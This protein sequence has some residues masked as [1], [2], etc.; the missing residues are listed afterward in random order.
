MTSQV[1]RPWVVG[2][3]VRRDFLGTRSYRL[4]FLLD[5]SYGVLDLVLYYFISQT[6]AGFTSEE[7]SGAPSYFAFAAAGIVLGVVITASSSGVAF[8]LREEQVTGTLEAMSTEPVTPFEICV[9]LVGFPFAFAAARSAFYLAIA[10][11]FLDL[12]LGDT[13]WPGLVLVLVASGAAL[14]PLGVLAG[15]AVLVFKRGTLV[16]GTLMYLLTILSGMVFPVSVLPD[17]LEPL[18][19]LVPLTYAFDGVRAA[20]FEGSGWESDV[21]ALGLWALVLW[22]LGLAAFAGALAYAKRAGSL[23]QY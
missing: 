23:A 15:A 17:W 18:A 6:F 13:S 21:L 16:S 4:A 2:A 19:E 9:G 1:L 8:R 22:P 14:A 12:D 10:A 11:I 20:L 7:L 5:V 3:V